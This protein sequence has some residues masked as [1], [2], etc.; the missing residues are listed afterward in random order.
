MEHFGNEF[1]TIVY[2]ID[3][4]NF[5][6]IMIRIITEDTDVVVL[7]VCCVYRE[8]VECEMQM[9]RWDMIMLGN[10]VCNSMACMPSPI[11]T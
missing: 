11:A 6:K 10:S 4:T 9:E 8:E 2:L 5:G 3:V 1:T 7:L